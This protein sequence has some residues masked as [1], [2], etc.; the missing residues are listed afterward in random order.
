MPIRELRKKVTFS[1]YE[2]TEDLN[3][4]ASLV[5]DLF[6][7]LEKAVQDLIYDDDRSKTSVQTT[8]PSLG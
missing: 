1:I 6:T 5:D 3:Q 2:E 7:L 4:V 8:R